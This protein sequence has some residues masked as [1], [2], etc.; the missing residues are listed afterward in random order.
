[1]EFMFLIRSG[2]DT[3]PYRL[4]ST[5]D[6]LG[7]A[8]RKAAAETSEAGTYLEGNALKHIGSATSLRVRRGRREYVD[9]PAADTDEQ[10]RGYFV[11]ECP[12]LDAA[13]SWAARLPGVQH[14]SVE[15]RPIRAYD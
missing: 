2:R 14:G 11:L 3:D 4:A 8:Y 7:D 12:D 5:V 10:L 13:L 1:M 15:I 9:G 6:E